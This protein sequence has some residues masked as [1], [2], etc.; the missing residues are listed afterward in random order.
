MVLMLLLLLLFARWLHRAEFARAARI[1]PDEEAAAD[2]PALPPMVAATG[3]YDG[4]KPA[5][6]CG[7]D[8]C[9]YS[10]TGWG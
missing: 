10:G 4:A 7:G 5:N 3:M 2:V 9:A 1:G 6:V 8:S